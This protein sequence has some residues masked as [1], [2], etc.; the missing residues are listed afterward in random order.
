MNTFR[1]AIAVALVVITV[2]T[3]IHVNA[4]V[5]IVM[6]TASAIVVWLGHML[7]NVKRSTWS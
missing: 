3:L 6:L 1:V 7:D 4:V 2:L 5:G